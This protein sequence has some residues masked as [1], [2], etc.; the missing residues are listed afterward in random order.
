MM[1]RSSAGA[2]RSRLLSTGAAA[3]LLLPS[4]LYAAEDVTRPTAASTAAP[5]DRYQ[6]WRDDDVVDWRAANARVREVGG[7]RTYLRESNPPEAGRDDDRGAPHG[8]H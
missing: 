2:A 3:C 7:W 6:S 4:A 8:G 5:F 1:K